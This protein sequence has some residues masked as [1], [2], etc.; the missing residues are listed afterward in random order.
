[1]PRIIE[2]EG[3]IL[4]MDARARAAPI[5]ATVPLLPPFG[6]LMLLAWRLLRPELWPMWIALPLGLADDM[7]SGQPFGTAAA[8]WTI[9]LLALD[10]LDKQL[11]WR[12]YWQE[13]A[14][15]AAAI[16]FCLLGGAVIAR[17]LAGGGELAVVAPQVAVSILVFPF[18][19][20]LCARIDR[21]RLA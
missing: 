12:D 11:I 14:L 6:L 7:L 5:V 19:S 10:T 18:V 17:Y 15:A 4:I 21:W 9:C 13:W 3:D 8:L 20:R 2:G 1:M 16:A